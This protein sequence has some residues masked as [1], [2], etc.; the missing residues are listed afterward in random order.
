MQIMKDNKSNMF[1]NVSIA[2]FVIGGIA[3]IAM[4]LMYNDNYDYQYLIFIGMAL[5]I[6]IKLI[7]NYEKKQRIKFQEDIK[8]LDEEFKR[9]IEQLAKQTVN[10][11]YYKPTP[12]EEIFEITNPA[13]VNKEYLK[14][15]YRELSKILHPDKGGDEE[16]MKSLNLCYEK[17][18]E[19]Y[20]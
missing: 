8:Q 18:K 17:L 14:N 13:S 16:A 19:K 10:K 15:K 1:I 3:D 9:Y 6:P 7:L 5:I 20:A 4:E 12:E 2:I 11:N